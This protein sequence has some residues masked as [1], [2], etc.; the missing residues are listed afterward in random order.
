M[1]I[2]ELE[3][4]RTLFNNIK[5]NLCVQLNCKNHP[6]LM[7]T[8]CIKEQCFID[9][10]NVTLLFETNSNNSYNWIM[11]FLVCTIVIFLYYIIQKTCRT[12]T[13]NLN[14]IIQKS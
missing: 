9:V 11:I 6:I 4:M 7:D 2:N 10:P 5:S 1:S 12:H 13:Q 3:E 8:N 14:L